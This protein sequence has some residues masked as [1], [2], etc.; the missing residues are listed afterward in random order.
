VSAIIASTAVTSAQRAKSAVPVVVDLDRFIDSQ[1]QGDR[2]FC[3]M[4]AFDLENYVLR[5]PR[6][7]W[8]PAAA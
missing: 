6:F 7:C 5:R 2:L 4:L 1:L 8:Q 3:L